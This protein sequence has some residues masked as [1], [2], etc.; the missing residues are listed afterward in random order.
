MPR[1]PYF[2]HFLFFVFS[3]TLYPACR[4]ISRGTLVPRHQNI[5]MKILNISYPRVRIEPT[6]YRVYIYTFVPCT[7]SGLQLHMYLLPIIYL[8]LESYYKRPSRYQP[9][10]LLVTSKHGNKVNIDLYCSFKLFG[11][12]QVYPLLLQTCQSWVTLKY[13]ER[14]LAC[15][16][17]GQKL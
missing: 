2:I 14:G 3:F 12:D 6:T 9:I 13:A 1:L 7:T 11:I 16:L 17:E 10:M 5:E 15:L 4:R 8:K